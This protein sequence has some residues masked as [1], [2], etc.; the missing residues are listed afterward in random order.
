V[1]L[2]WAAAAA[3][4]PAAGVVRGRPWDGRV[5]VGADDGAR[6]RV[7]LVDVGLGCETPVAD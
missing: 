6:S 4:R 5:L 3:D 2:G 7:S 1:R